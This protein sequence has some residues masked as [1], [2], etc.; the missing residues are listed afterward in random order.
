MRVAY[1]LLSVFVALTLLHVYWACGGRRGWN[2]ALPERPAPTAPDFTS[3][4]VKALTPSHAATLA[5]AGALALTGLLVSL[6][7]GLFAPPLRHWALTTTLTIAALV[8][9]VRAVG[10]FHWVGLFKQAS[11]S[12]F[13][14]WDTAVYSP[15]CFALGVGLLKVA[16]G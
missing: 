10:D 9:L 4:R 13:A 7:A 14:H 2:A 3:A 16:Y 15:L 11:D 5:V 1:L 8:F 12:T 6:R